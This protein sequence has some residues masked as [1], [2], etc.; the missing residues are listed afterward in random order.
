[1]GRRK[2]EEKEIEEEEEEEVTAALSFS[3]LPLSSTHSLTHSNAWLNT[4]PALCSSR[5]STAVLSLALA[6]TAYFN[7]EPGTQLIVN[8]FARS[9]ATGLFMLSARKQSAA[10]A[11]KGICLLPLLEP[12]EAAHLPTCVDRGGLIAAERRRKERRSRL[13]CLLPRK[14]RVTGLRCGAEIVVDISLHFQILMWI[15][16]ILFC[17]LKRLGL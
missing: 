2:S 7:E 16:V 3:L 5:Y 14:E 4:F 17:L 9:H 10:A 15:P 1:V 12:W 11:L 8:S 6:P 13:T